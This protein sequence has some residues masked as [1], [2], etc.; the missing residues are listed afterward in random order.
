MLRKPVIEQAFFFIE[1]KHFS[2][3]LYDFY[4]AAMDLSRRI[5]N[6]VLCNQLVKILLVISMELN[7]VYYIIF[8]FPFRLES[9][10]VDE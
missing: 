6:K 3:F 9:C 7:I 2:L 5:N 4:R 8:R 10:Y 1:K